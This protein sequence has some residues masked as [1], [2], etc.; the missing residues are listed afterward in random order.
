MTAITAMITITIIFALVYLLVFLV[1]RAQEAT[2]SMNKVDDSKMCKVH[3]WKTIKFLDPDVKAKVDS[4]DLSGTEEIPNSNYCYKCG[5][6]PNFNGMLKPANLKVANEN[7]DYNDEQAAKLADLGE[8]QAEF[9]EEY[10]EDSG[11][12]E[13]QKALVREGYQVY[14]DFTKGIHI[15]LDIRA[16]LRANKA[17]EQEEND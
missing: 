1:N 6:V 13:E 10:L 2:E 11:Y 14:E 7:H 15:L 12:T 17:P 9:I 16:T 3:K 4:G 5:Y 8:F